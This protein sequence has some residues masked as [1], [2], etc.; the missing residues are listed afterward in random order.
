MDNLP[1]ISVIV[2]V[3]KVEKYLDQCIRS[4]AEQSYRNLE[5][6]LV[7]DGSPDGCGAICDA[8]AEKDNRIRVIH[9]ENGGA[10]LARN[11]GLEAA[12]GELIGFI[13]SDDYIE[14]HMYSHLQSLMGPEVDLAECELGMTTEDTMDMDDGSRFETL[15]VSME[16]AMILHIQD[17]I[18]RQTPPNKLYRRSAIADARFPVGNLIDDEFF[19]YLV[20]GN[21][22]KLVHSSCCMYAY[23]QQQ[24]SAMNRPY[25]MKRLQGLK[26]KRERLAYLKAHVPGAVNEAKINLFYSCL[27]AMQGSLQYLT[28]EEQKQAKQLI[29]ETVKDSLPLPME[30]VDSFKKK[31]LMKFAEKNMEATARVLNFLI[32]IHVLT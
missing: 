23:R 21:C 5:I 32:K 20:I 30:G 17:Q 26:A 1:L 24:G 6:I 18:F 28:I 12:S 10:G 13:D 29:Q 16:E 4:I 27:Y 11:V 15:E 22:R 19:T 2:P 7:D 8:W 14:P 3:Y 25:S 9:K 31:M